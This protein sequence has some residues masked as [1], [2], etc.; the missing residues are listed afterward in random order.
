MS[1]PTLTAAGLTIQDL[2]TIRAELASEVR[3]AL[4]LDTLLA[5]ADDSVIGQILGVLA[6][7]ESSIQELLQDVYLQSYVIDADGVQLDKAVAFGGLRRKAAT[8]TLVALDVE[9]PTGAGITVAAGLLIE[10]DGTSDRFVTDAAVVIGAGATVAVGL[11][12]V[13]AGATDVPAGSSW[14]WVSTFAGSSDLVMAN[15][16]AGTTGQELETDPALRLRF[17]NSRHAPGGGTLGAV[18]AA[19]RALD[20][21]QEAAVYENDTDVT[22]VTSPETIAALPPHSFVVVARG[23][24]TASEIGAAILSRK[25]S[26]IRAWGASFVT[27]EDADG[28][29]HSIGYRTAVALPVVVVLT[30]TGSAVAY[31]D[32]VKAALHDWADALQ[33]GQELQHLALLAQ[34]LA[35]APGATGVSGTVAGAALS[36]T[37]A[38]DVGYYEYA[39]IAVA[40]V[41]L[42]FA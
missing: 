2:A 29:G 3:A 15:A 30:I 31:S 19:V 39:T 20:T 35:A 28:V 26:G 6:E 16:A 13:V 18:I 42:V 40:D 41:T 33:V 7:R 24:F 38:V 8:S 5:D 22:G 36:T 9:N 37:G 17:F 10:L 27:V 23:T 34:V 21:V 11:R 1:G 12:A 14:T 25:P 4:G 32:A